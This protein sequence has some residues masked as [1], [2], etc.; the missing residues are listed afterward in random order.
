VFGLILYGTFNRSLDN[1]LG[2]LSLSPAELQ[3]VNE[4]RPRLAAIE[5]NDARVNDAVAQAFISGYRTILLV[6]AGLSVASSLTAAFLLD[7]G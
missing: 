4:Q 2:R 5:S 6:A 3:H 1:G 7:P